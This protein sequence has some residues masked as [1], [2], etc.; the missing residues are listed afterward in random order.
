VV[1]WLGD[2][3]RP[4]EADIGPGWR[5]RARSSGKGPRAREVTNRIFLRFFFTEED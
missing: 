2:C 4:K 1:A 3:R 5:D